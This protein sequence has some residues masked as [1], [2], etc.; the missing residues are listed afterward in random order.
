VHFTTEFSPFEIVYG[1]NIF[2]SHRFDS[3]VVDEMVTLDNNHKSQV[4]KTLHESVQ[5]Q[6]KKRNRV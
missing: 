3:F 4:M 6:I 2:N 5:Q 1:F